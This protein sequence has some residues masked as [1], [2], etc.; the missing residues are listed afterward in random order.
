MDVDVS[1]SNVEVLLAPALQELRLDLGLGDFGDCY[2]AELVEV[3]APSQS[4]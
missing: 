4:Q 3:T 2:G 1:E